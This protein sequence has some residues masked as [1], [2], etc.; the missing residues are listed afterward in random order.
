M[1]DANQIPQSFQSEVARAVT[2]RYLLFRPRQYRASGTKRWPLILFL[3]GAGERGTDLWR[4]AVH[5]PPKVVEEQP[6]FPF[7]VVSPQ[8]PNGRFWSNEILLPLVE[9]VLENHRVD[10]RRVY[11]TGLSMGGYGAWKLAMAY[12]EKFAAVA[13]VC[14]GGDVLPVMLADTQKQRSLRTLAVWAFHG[15]DDPVVPLEESERMIA[16]LQ[17]IGNDA[18]LTVYPEC[19]HDSWTQTY[20]NP[21]LYDWFLEHRRPMQREPRRKV[22]QAFS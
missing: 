12:P 14:G 19:G 16:A 9:E 10:R 13:P 17:R 11:L 2:A 15:A 20:N 1:P 3:H 22:R 5:G 8:C 6:D 18:K 4:V 7:L 21:A